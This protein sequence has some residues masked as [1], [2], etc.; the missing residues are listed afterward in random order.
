MSGLSNILSSNAYFI[1]N[2][3]LCK[4][5]GLVCAAIVGELYSEFAFSSSFT[6]LIPR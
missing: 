2:K 4:K 6:F 5:L 3:M 1:V